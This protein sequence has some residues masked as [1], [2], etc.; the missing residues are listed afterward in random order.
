MASSIFCIVSLF[1]PYFWLLHGVEQHEVLSHGVGGEDNTNGAID[2]VVKA[3]N[4]PTSVP[5]LDLQQPDVQPF[6]DV[7]LLKL[8]VCPSDSGLQDTSKIVWVELG[9]GL[10]QLPF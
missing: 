9:G 2:L 8:G 7:L 5:R 1:L 10:A 4:V 3:E 6:Q